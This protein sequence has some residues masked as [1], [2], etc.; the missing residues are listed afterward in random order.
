MITGHTGFK[1][2]WLWQWLVMFGVEVVGIALPPDAEPNLF[3][4]AGIGDSAGSHLSD[5]RERKKLHVLLNAVQPEIVFHMAAQSLVRRSYRE[6]A[7]TFETNVLGTAYVLDAI[8]FAPSVRCALIVT[9]DKCYQPRPGLDAYLEEDPLGGY[10]PYSASKACA[11]IVVECW[12]RSFP[13]PAT[14]RGIASLRAGNVIGGG[15]WAQDRL[16]PDCVRAF[17]QGKAVEIRNPNA[18]R[19][20]QH[21]LDALAGYLLLAERLYGDPAGFGQ[22]WNF[23]P[24]PSGSKTVLSVVEHFAAHWG[25]NPEWRIAEGLTLSEEPVL[26]IDA[27]KARTQL[28][29]RSVLNL[30]DSLGWTAEWYRKQ[31]A[32]E[33][34]SKLCTEQ[35]C[36]FLER[37]RSIAV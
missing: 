13:N 5:I 25:D 26:A 32:G 8:R 27:S 28:G 10:D 21:V 14:P 36:R 16:I 18:V 6:P 23:G 12:R 7:E 33:N 22:A 31:E 35:I 29:W 1:G 20:W 37:A 30:D 34:A 9:S 2:S 3:H 19:P 4:L 24:D 15:D 17:Q 11:E